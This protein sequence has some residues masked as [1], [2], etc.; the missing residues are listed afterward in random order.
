MP[1]GGRHWGDVDG[2]GLYDAVTVY[3]YIAHCDRW[4]E[5]TPVGNVPEP[6]RVSVSTGTGFE[7][8]L[9]YLDALNRYLAPARVLATR[10]CTHQQGP[11]SPAGQQYREQQKDVRRDHL[12]AM[13]DFNA[14]GLVD[15]VR[16]HDGSQDLG[17]PSGQLLV[18]TGSTWRDYDEGRAPTIRVPAI[19]DSETTT[20]T[21]ATL[22]ERRHT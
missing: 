19:P 8:R 1:P 2:D 16:N 13:G 5:E 9:S 21:G 10:V 3:P 20:G 17:N 14:D 4:E 22:R 15:I 7:P 18:N 6:R 11:G 12:M